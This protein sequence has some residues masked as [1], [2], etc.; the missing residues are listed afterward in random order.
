MLG[1]GE[2]QE[3][4]VWEAAMCAGHYKINN[5]IAFVDR[6]NGQIDGLV[7]TIMTI[8]PLGDKFSSFG[9]HVLHIDGHNY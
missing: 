6:N 1:D 2:L 3:G 7:D 9:W 4:Q 5:L 8:E